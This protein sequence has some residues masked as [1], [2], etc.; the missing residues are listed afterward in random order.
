MWIVGYQA[1][2][3]QGDGR[4]GHIDMPYRRG[5]EMGGAEGRMK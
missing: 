2:G 4:D 3:S 1:W 5:L